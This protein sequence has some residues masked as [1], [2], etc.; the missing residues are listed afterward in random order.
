MIAILQI[1]RH[2]I[3]DSYYPI[4]FLLINS[5]NPV[6]DLEVKQLLI[7]QFGDSR[8]LSSLIQILQRFKQVFNESPLTFYNHLQVLTA[9]VHCH[10]QELSLPN[11]DLK[12]AQTSSFDAMVL[13]IL[14]TDPDRRLG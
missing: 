6:S 4:T 7:S 2:R 14:L 1:I 10:I 8:N 3:N 13:N 5:R 9:K 11:A 12:L